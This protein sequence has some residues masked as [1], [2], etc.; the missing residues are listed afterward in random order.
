MVERTGEDVGSMGADEYGYR[1]GTYQ[2]WQESICD[3]STCRR[4]NIQLND[5]QNIYYSMAN[6]MMLQY[7]KSG[8][9]MQQCSGN[10]IRD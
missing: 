3:A 10:V 6:S 8:V 9:T 7:D 4:K 2:R 5:F 1:Q